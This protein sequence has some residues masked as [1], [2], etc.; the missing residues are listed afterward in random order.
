MGVDTEALKVSENK[1]KVIAELSGKAFDDV[2]SLA[3]EIKT[4]MNGGKAENSNKKAFTDIEDAKTKEA[5]DYLAKGGIVSGRTETEFCPNDSVKREEFAK[6]LVLSLELYDEKADTDFTDVSSD[7]WYYRYVAS[8]TK[9]EL[10]KGYGDVFGVGD[11]ITRQDVATIVYRA[12]GDNLD[13]A[14][15]VEPNLADKDK[16]SDYAKEAVYALIATETMSKNGDN[17]FAPTENATRAH[18]AEAIYNL[19]RGNKKGE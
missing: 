2:E 19:C 17:S 16:I 9:K 15:V 14:G 12:F 4:V 10:I 11:F 8:A 5:V 1:E 7:A 6:M 13:K 18:V 3:E